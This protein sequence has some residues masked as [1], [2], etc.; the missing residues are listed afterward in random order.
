MTESLK[1][2]VLG[3]RFMGKA[4]ANALARLPMFFPDAPDVERSVIVGR[5]EEALADAADRF[6]FES[7]ATDWRDVVG[8]VDV[9][10]NLGPNHLHAEPSI[11][12][13]EA[14]AHVFC[15]KPLAPT[16]EEA[17]EM[18]DAARDADGVAGCAFNYRFVPAIQYAKGLIE[19]GELG[20][21]HHVRG[22]YL[23]DWLVDPEA[24]WAWR[25]DKDLAGSGALGDLGAHT[26]DLVRFL[27]GDSDVAGDITRVSGH[28]QTFVDERPVPGTDEYKPVT[29]DDAYTAQAEFENG[30]VGS[31][32]ASRFAD[33][34]KNDHTIEIHGSE[35]S[36]TFSL[37]RLNELEVKTGDARGY[38]TVL[39]TD[40]SDPYVGNWWPPGHVIG[41]EHTFVHENYEFLTAVAER[42]AAGSRTQSGEAAEGGEFHPSF[43]D[44]YEVQE[45]LDA[46][47]RS[48]ETGEWV[49]LE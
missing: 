44:A 48:D 27:V 2:G 18:R 46:I 38:E 12:A 30:A 4:H 39:V 16:L 5:D 24:P 21:I 37:E 41:W 47:E 32:E 28:L 36:L 29:V 13:L 9:F 34:H 42:A 6:G 20:E 43:E 35:G 11:A 23:Q 19:D 7:T 31:F 22:R 26:I 25:M 45:V 14:G 33:G 3:Y 10:Y 49:S 1:I 40:E 15:E 17:E 8:D